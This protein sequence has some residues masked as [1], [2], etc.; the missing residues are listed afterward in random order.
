MKTVLVVFGTRPE[1]I[2]M[3]PV[4]RELKKI[5][6]I[7]TLVCVTGQHREMLDSVL[8]AFDVS[9]DFDLSVMREGQTLFDVTAAVMSGMKSILELVKPDTVLVHGD[10][11]TAFASAL[12]AYYMKIPI[13]HIEAGL[14]TYDIR[15]PFPEEFN[16]RAI[17]IVTDYNFAPTETARRNLLSEGVRGESIF[18]TGNTVI[19]A[20]RTT[21]NQKF[22]HSELD[23]ATDSRLVLLTAHRRESIG[24][25]MRNMM[26]AIKRVVEEKR[27]VKVIYPIHPNPE[28]QKIA[29]E[30]LSG[31]ERFHLIPPL[32]VI[33]FHNFLAA[34]HLV[35]T[36]SGGI[37]EEAPALGKPV[38]VM[39]DTTE[40]PEAVDAGCARL[41]GT[42][43]QGIY[44]SF[45]LLLNDS[46]VYSSMASCKNPY[47]DGT[48]SVK[49][50]EII[51][52]LI[53]K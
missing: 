41:V 27:D 7:K 26:R 6:I 2:K 29:E 15:R 48:A 50:T 38:L 40:R 52:K 39:R 5:G 33:E 18:V 9:A 49:I 24:V 17:S 35:L 36:D 19:D 20:L 45:T 12:A 46:R 13:G 25:P 22:R 4:V 10:T 21:V 1:A 42:E 51:K 37:Q 34:A 31:L 23:W 3:C 30:E 28:A 47:G 43:E 11:T 8:R 16:R 14:R 53:C 32:D 44:E